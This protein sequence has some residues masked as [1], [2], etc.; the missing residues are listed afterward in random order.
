MD[1]WIWDQVGLELSDVDVQGTV[2]SERCSQRGDDLGNK[3]VQVGVGWSFDVQVSS[4]DVIDGF[5]V[6]HDC[7]VG[8]LQKGVG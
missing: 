8:V 5:V 1:S 4:A 7:D 6:E 3:S 2:E